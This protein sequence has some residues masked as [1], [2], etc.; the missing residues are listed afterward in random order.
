MFKRGRRNNSQ[1]YFDFRKMYDV[2]LACPFEPEEIFPSRRDLME[3]FE[4][5]DKIG[6]VIEKI[7]KRPYLPHKEIN[8][9]WDA[10]KMYS[11]PND[12]V[13]P[14]A[15]IVIGYL[16]I[17]SD[18]TGIML[19]S[20]QMNRIPISYLYHEYKDL[21]RLKVGIYNRSNNLFEIDMGFKSEVYDLI[22]Y[23][24]ENELLNKL[25][26]SLKK[27]YENNS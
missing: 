25:E 16:G 23:K 15:N 8:L 26:L 1:K 3:V 18:T 5:Y 10:E 27:F 20:A 21:E 11:I 24:D 9:K 4:F 6:I 22:E 12:I 17:A 13:I 14:N 2:V 7:G 19:S